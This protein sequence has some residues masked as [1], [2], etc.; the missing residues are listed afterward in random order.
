MYD[1]LKYGSLA[2]YIDEVGRDHKIDLLTVDYYIA[3]GRYTVKVEGLEDHFTEYL[4]CTVHCYIS[5]QHAPS[6]PD[7]Q[8]PM[9]VEIK[10]LEGVKTLNIAG[11]DIELQAG[12]TVFI[13]AN[14]VHRATN[15]YASMML[16]IGHKY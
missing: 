12:E 3:E 5:P 2:M 13:P 7:H 1:F 6:F 9:N 4:P 10:C 11:K 16:S 8:D 15:K 14:T